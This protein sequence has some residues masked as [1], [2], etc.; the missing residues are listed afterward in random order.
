[1]AG[2][3][4]VTGCF[5]IVPS[6]ANKTWIVPSK[7]PNHLCNVQ[8]T[9]NSISFSELKHNCYENLEMPLIGFLH[10]RSL[11]TG[12]HSLETEHVKGLCT[13]KNCA[14]VPRYHFRGCLE[15]SISLKKK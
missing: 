9:N 10:Q 13:P 12:N 4:T 15:F 8:K 1:M 11:N 6:P 7:F 5:K 3:I 2:D 14:T